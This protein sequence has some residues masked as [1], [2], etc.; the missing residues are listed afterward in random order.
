MTARISDLPGLAIRR[1]TLI[2]VV[3]LLIVI[4]GLSALFGIEV[5]ELPDVDR[6]VVMETTALGAAWLAGHHTGF[7]PGPEEFSKRWKLDRR[8]EPAMD[9]ATRSRKFAGWQNALRRTLTR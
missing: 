6:P 1:P 7:Y 9:E 5:R 2:V 4:A 3:N 8:F